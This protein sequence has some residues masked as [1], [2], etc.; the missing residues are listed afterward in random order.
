MTRNSK[1][2]EMQMVKL[3]AE[4]TGLAIVD[5]DSALRCGLMGESERWLQCIGACISP[6][7]AVGPLSS[8]T[9]FRDI[10]I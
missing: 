2:E 4:L 8:A 6:E 7:D 1:S 9:E 10:I 3:G 5:G